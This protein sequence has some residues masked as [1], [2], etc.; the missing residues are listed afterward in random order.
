L[1]REDVWEGLTEQGVTAELLEQN[2]AAKSPGQER[3]NE[4]AGMLAERAGQP[5]HG[6]KGGL[7]H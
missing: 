6:W 5:T 3:W 4:K 7:L 2:K 1:E